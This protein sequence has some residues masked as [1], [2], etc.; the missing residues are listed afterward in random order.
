M[1]GIVGI[2]SRHGAPVDE[3]RL[4]RMTAFLAYRGPDGRN[5]WLGGP[6]GFGH[7]LL[8]TT[9][10]P[11]DDGQPVSLDGQVWITADARVDGR[12]DLVT[13]LESRGRVG[14]RSASD[15]QLILHAYHAWADECV[16]FLLGDF[17]FA[18]WDARTR[19]LFC[20]RDH[21]G[22]KPFYYAQVRDGFIF[23]N[24]LDCVR[25]HP[26]VG[27]SLNALAIGDFL[28]FGYN[29]EP[30]TTTFTDVQRL[31]PAHSLTYQ[32]G[33]TN[34][35]RYWTLPTNGRIRYQRAQEY[36]DHFQ[37]VLRVAVSDRLRMNR[38]GVWMSGGL[39]S[40]SITATARQ[41]LS[42]GGTPFELRAHTIVYDTL[43]RDEER[44]YAQIAADALGVEVDFFPADSHLPFDGWDRADFRAPE[45]TDDLFLVMRMRQLERAASH[46]RV[47]LCGEGGD[48]VLWG[49]YLVDLLPRMRSL[50]LLADITRSLVVH[51]RRPGVGIR[52]RIEKWLGHGS[53]PPSYPAWLN[54]VFSDRLGLRARWTEWHALELTDHPLRPEA[55]GRLA[56]APWPWYFE[57]LD[58]GVTRIPV[59]GRYPFLD[60]RLVNYLLAIPPLP[61]CIDKQLLRLA[62]RGVLPDPIRSRRKA[63]LAGDP[64]LAHLRKPDLQ[65]VDRFAPIPELARYIDRKAIPRL[66]GACAPDDSWLHVRPL[67]L[68]YWLKRGRPATQF[69]EEISDDYQVDTLQGK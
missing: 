31:A 55:H 50:E 7:T 47:L 68:N 53:Q 17:A 28:L 30:T 24:T 19:R 54:A 26:D 9:C 32:N 43:I 23:S 13:L 18:I 20:A 38:A 64:L 2:V 59:E 58:P 48:E 40:T 42:E 35:K 3:R 14:L 44:R 34:L 67:C 12:A 57:S 4:R 49:S 37:E 69:E 62:M 39:D 22:V 27:D 11:R 66:V 29:A 46:S 36:V 41:L 6:V 1:S 63:P 8:R 61:W 5:V 10:E 51:R 65:W 16:N 21:F 25:L 56:T 45:P 15:A 52:A 33:A 60:L